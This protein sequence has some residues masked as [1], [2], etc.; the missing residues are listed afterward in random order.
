MIILKD[1]EKILA[2]IHRHWIVIAGKMTLVIMLLLPAAGAIVF[3][4]ALPQNFAGFLLYAVVIYLLFVLFLAFSFW[5]DYYLDMWIITDKRIID[6]EQI[7][8]FKREASE[9]PFFRVQDVTVS[10]PGF[11]ATLL[12]FG[13][14][15]IQTAGEQNFYIR[16]IASVYETKEIIM[17]Q[18]NAAH[19]EV[20]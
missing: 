6:I 4:S 18:I 3:I 8:L 10:I 15:T 11:L 1:G 16:D 12:K 2:V 5:I 9:I 13:T 7:G 19:S 20:K 14:L 17:G